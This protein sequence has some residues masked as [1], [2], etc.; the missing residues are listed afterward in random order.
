MEEPH[1]RPCLQIGVSELDLLNGGPPLVK[2][3]R[4][5]L[6]GTAL[7]GR[8]LHVETGQDDVHGVIAVVVDVDLR[9]A[10]EVMSRAS[11]ASS[12]RGS[13][14]NSC[15][16]DRRRSCEAVPPA[17]IRCETSAAGW[18][19]QLLGAANALVTANLRWLDRHP[20]HHLPETLDVL[21][22]VFRNSNAIDER[23]RPE[24]GLDI[25]APGSPSGSPW[26]APH[27]RASVTK[28]VVVD[29]TANETRPI[30]YL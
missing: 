29:P 18:Q 14:R 28:Y 30:S 10:G 16:T 8:P 4:D 17:S 7:V 1:H 21:R 22:R 20:R 15:R 5:P 11:L 26:L 24:V 23:I 19:Y 27:I 25:V 2:L 12:P 6:G 3:E 9:W 13:A